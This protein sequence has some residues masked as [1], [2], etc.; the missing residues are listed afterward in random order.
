MLRLRERR[1]ASTRSQELQESQSERDHKA[2]EN[3]HILI[4]ARRPFRQEAGE[5]SAEQQE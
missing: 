1:E 3:H 4:M 5:Q 2:T